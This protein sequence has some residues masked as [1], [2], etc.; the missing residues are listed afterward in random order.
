L[1]LSE[2]IMESLSTESLVCGWTYISQTQTF[3]NTN[4]SLK[5][6]VPQ[7]TVNLAKPL[8]YKFR[9][10]EY[11]DGEGK[12]VKV[13]L[14]VAVYEHTNMGGGCSMKCDWKDVERV[15]LPFVE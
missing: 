3:Q 2:V 14:Q 15:Q 1:V 12:I 9:V 4:S 10:A 8:T 11:V 5:F 13:N 7:A 6:E